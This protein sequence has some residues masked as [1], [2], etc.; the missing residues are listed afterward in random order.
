LSELFSK[1]RGME[2]QLAVRGPRTPPNKFRDSWCNLLFGEFGLP[3]PFAD[4]K[5]CSHSK[6]KK[7]ELLLKFNII[8]KLLLY[9]ALK[10]LDHPLILL[11][12]R[13]YQPQ[14]QTGDG[15]LLTSRL[16]RC[17]QCNSN[18]GEVG[19]LLCIRVFAY[20]KIKITNQHKFL[21]TSSP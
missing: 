1:F 4:L 16:Q 2:L 6:K 7:N 17:S 20:T 9:Y 12:R 18:P 8:L 14:T 5:I 3:C 10:K 11:I 21:S 15:V 19:V 13:L